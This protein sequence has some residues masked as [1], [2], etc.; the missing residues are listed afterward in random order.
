MV[1]GGRVPNSLLASLGLVVSQLMLQGSG[2][3]PDT[4]DEL[5]KDLQALAPT[6]HPVRGTPFAVS[7]SG[8]NAFSQLKA[9][10]ALQGL[11]RP[12]DRATADNEWKV[13]ETIVVEHNRSG[14]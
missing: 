5:A 1:K 10:S 13:T 14:S 9:H 4:T 8:A 7:L 6:A 12:E 3:S 2:V 11:L